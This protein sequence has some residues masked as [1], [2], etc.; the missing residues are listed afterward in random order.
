VGTL[1]IVKKVEVGA[2]GSLLAWTA[3][4]ATLMV[5][6]T[7]AYD[8]INVPK[9]LVVAVGGFMA[10]GAL[11]AQ[12]KVLAE[13]RYRLVLIFGMA[14]F[15]DLIL[16]LVISGTNFTQEFFGTFGRATGFVA[17]A[18][19]TFLLVAAAIAGHAQTLSKVSWALVIT[20]GASIVYGLI[21]SV[22]A[23]PVNW[24]SS[25]NPVFG[26]LGNPNFQSSFVGF[27]GVLVFALLLNKNYSLIVRLLL[28]VDLLL[29]AYVISTT[30]SQQGF[31]VLAGGISIVGIVWIYTSKAKLLTIPALILGLIGG[32]FVTMGS[33]NSGP[34]AGLLYKASVTYRGDYWRAGWKMTLEH[35]LLGVG[36]DSYGDW[37]RRA[38]TVEATLRRGPDVVSNAAHN[39]LLDLS[40][41]GGF[42]LVFIYLFMIVLVLISAIKVF[43]RSQGF[44]P[45]FTGLFAVWIAYQAQSIISLNQLGLAVWG[46]IISGLL[47]GYEINSRTEIDEAPTNRGVSKGRSASAIAQQKVSAGVL[48]WMFVGAVAG[49]GVGAPPVMASSK[50]LSALN[51][52][53]P[54]VVQQ[55][56]YIRPLDARY[57]YLIADILLSNKLMA[58]AAV[59]SDDSIAKF[60]DEYGVWTVRSKIEGLPQEQIDRAL[61]EMK[62]LDPNNPNLK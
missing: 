14:F 7:S 17:Y 31:L 50:L 10:L 8:P 11:I 45:T 19:L 21:Q 48:I 22:D 25:Y 53:D 2:L 43:R 57:M 16:V 29:S 32:I 23:D 47:I 49:F 4:L 40:S 51:S 55:A 12:R 62:R 56:A 13:K 28:F 34:L 54:K 5:L 9:L 38:R 52:Q 15:V 30:D 3:G 35:P 58:E 41:N 39:V 24:V 37:Y 33:L 36:L 18:S 1:G 60:K 20:G 44:N 61:R 42:P 6:P 27:N 59:V 46:W 26:F